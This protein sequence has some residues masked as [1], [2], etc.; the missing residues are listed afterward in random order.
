[1]S[2]PT[3]TGQDTAAVRSPA[4][5]ARCQRVGAAMAL[6]S[7]YQPPSPPVSASKRVFW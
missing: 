4:S 3:V 2:A 6:A 1:M 7:K 5:R